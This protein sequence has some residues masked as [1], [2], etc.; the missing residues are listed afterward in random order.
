MRCI[1][2]SI[3]YTNISLLTGAYQ[4]LDLYAYV[5]RLPAESG[6]ELEEAIH[7]EYRLLSEYSFTSGKLEG[8]ETLQ[9]M[10]KRVSAEGRARIEKNT[11]MKVTT[12]RGKKNAKNHDGE[13][14]HEEEKPT[15][16]KRGGRR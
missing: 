11:G 15:K 10:L 9:G 2:L 12:A 1:V 4:P 8:V 3:K 14:P 16:K 5:L 13:H 7:A 6:G